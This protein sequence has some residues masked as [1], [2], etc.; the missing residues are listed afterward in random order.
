MTLGQTLFG[1]AGRIGRGTFWLLVIAVFLLDLAVVALVSDWI[2]SRYL[3]AGVPHRP[4]G[5]VIGAGFGLLI[6]GIVSAWAAGGLMVKRAHDLERSGW[7]L[8]IGLIPVYGPARLVM[9]LGFLEG[10]SG[11][12]R[13]GEGASIVRRPHRRPIDRPAVLNLEV[14]EPV[15][16]SL[17]EPVPMPEL[18][19]ASLSSDNALLFEGLQSD[20][21][22]GA[23]PL[24]AETGEALAEGADAEPAESLDEVHP[25]MAWGKT[26]RA[27]LNWPEFQALSSPGLLDGILT[28]TA[29]EPSE[30]LAAGK[31]NEPTI[32]V[33]PA[34]EPQTPAADELAPPLAPADVAAQAWKPAPSHQAYVELEAHN[35]HPAADARAPNHPP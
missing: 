21:A 16:G 10:S 3:E 34:H 35:T 28:Q 17:F 15:Q 8:L 5:D 33:L 13:Y 14:A 4:G 12:N 19:A 23:P 2:R 9:D 1:F 32:D 22:E 6:V 24:V 20:S 27:D 29:A 30:D 26:Y 7:W 25:L 31:A 11:A 18:A